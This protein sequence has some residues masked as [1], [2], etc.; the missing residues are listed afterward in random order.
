MDRQIKTFMSISPVVFD[1]DRHSI[2]YGVLLKI[3]WWISN[4]LRTNSK[5]L[6][7][8]QVFKKPRPSLSPTSHYPSLFSPSAIPTPVSDLIQM[9]G[10]LFLEH[11]SFSLD[12]SYSA[13]W[14]DHPTDL[15]TFFRIFL[16]KAFLFQCSMVYMQFFSKWTS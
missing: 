11:L 16:F 10:A 15:L 8:A 4:A 7:L 9:F 1:G 3:F 14:Q 13:F 12:F 6:H 5:L 2:H